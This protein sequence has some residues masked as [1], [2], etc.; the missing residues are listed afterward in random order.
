[1]FIITKNVN[2]LLMVMGLGQTKIIYCDLI[3]KSGL[4]VV[5]NSNP[6]DS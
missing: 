4:V 2:I 1:M 5:H 6:L 3:I